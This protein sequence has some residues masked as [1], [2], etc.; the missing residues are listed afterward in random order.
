MPQCSGPTLS[1]ELKRDDGDEENLKTE[2]ETSVFSGPVFRCFF[3]FWVRRPKSPRSLTWSHKASKAQLVRPFQDV[4]FPPDLKRNF[5]LWNLVGNWTNLCNLSIR[6]SRTSSN[7]DHGSITSGRRETRLT[8]HHK[9]VEAWNLIY[10]QQAYKFQV[11]NKYLL[12]PNKTK[13]LFI[14]YIYFLCERG[15]LNSSRR[16][17]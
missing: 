13:T 9:T 8:K 15:E 12:F 11:V 5:D 2:N 17:S 16:P 4:F 7:S 1:P 14:S 3:G 10:V 6:F